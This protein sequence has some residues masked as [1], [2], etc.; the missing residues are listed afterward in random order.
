MTVKD[1]IAGIIE[2]RR[3]RKVV[4]DHAAM[5]EVYNRSGL[6]AEETEKEVRG[7][8]RLGVIHI[9]RTLNDYYIKL[10]ENDGMEIHE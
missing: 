1:T 2:E 6:T 8:F 5:R 9:G 3:A 7:L 10:T 4:P